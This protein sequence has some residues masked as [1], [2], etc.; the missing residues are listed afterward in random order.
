VRN[1]LALA[2][3]ASLVVALVPVAP[4]RLVGGLG[5]VDTGQLV[6]PT[7]YPPTDQPGLDQLSAMPSVHVVWAVVCAGAVIYCL[8][9][10]W[11]WLAVLYP[12]LTVTV[13]VATGNHFWAD[14][15]AGTL[16]VTLSALAV[17]AARRWLLQPAS[18]ALRSA[19]VS[20]S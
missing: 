17:S 7:V 9:S 1:T 13:V 10:R 6:G 14:A 5:V 18:A 3:A 8:R 15:A 19:P 12:L 11:R 20:P 2:T 4:P 16:I